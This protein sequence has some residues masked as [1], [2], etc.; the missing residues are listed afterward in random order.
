MNSRKVKEIVKFNIQ[1]NIQ[2]KWFIIFNIITLLIMICTANIQNIQNYL[3]SRDIHLF[4][5]NIC[6]EI[7]DE[8]NLATEKL[9]QAFEDE[10]FEIKK[11]TENT[12]SKDTIPDD[13]VIVEVYEEQDDFVTAKVISKDSMGSYIYDEISNVLTQVRSDLFAEKNEIEKQELEKLNEPVKIEEILLSVDAENSDTKEIIKTVSTLIIYFVS[14]LVFS[15]IANEIAQEKVSKS[16]EYVLTSV[17]E[18]EYLLAKIISVNGII[19]IQGVYLLIY[20]FIGNLVNNVINI[21]ALQAVDPTILTTGIDTGIILYIITVLGYGILTLILMSIIQATL[22]SKTVSMNEAGN[23]TALLTTI[24]I[25]AYIVTLMII[26]PYTKMNT[27]LY[28]LSCIPLLSNYFIPAIMVIGQATPLQIIISLALLIISIPITF[29]ICA[30]IFKNGV[31]DYKPVKNRKKQ[32]SKVQLSFEEEQKLDLTKKKYRKL[33]FVVGMAI[34][35]Y[36]T[37]STLLSFIIP[38]FIS[39]FLNNFLNEEQVSYLANSLL[40]IIS[41]GLAAAFVLAYST[42]STKPTKTSFRNA[43]KI[44]LEGIFLLMLFQI[45]LSY[46]Y[47]LIGIDYN[48]ANAVAVTDTS[49]VLTNILYFIFLAI[50]PAIFEELLF[51]KALITASRKFGTI[52]AVVFSA[53]LFG[54]IHM[55]LGQFIFAFLIGLVFGWI[56]VRTDNIKIPMILHLINNGFACLITIIEN[57]MTLIV[58]TSFILLFT[59]IGC[60]SLVARLIKSIKNKELKINLKFNKEEIKNYK[61]ILTD[62]TFIIALIFTALQFVLTEYMLRNVL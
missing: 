26:T 50:V 56:Y 48:I 20:Y 58:I 4:D 21:S 19:L 59:I 34:I 1:K 32:K 31:L 22:S 17:T 45:G 6:I 8:N 14:I 55:N 37:L 43:T 27:L 25:L 62:Y 33:G 49:N 35:M 24:T 51:R 29:N 30:V 53:L 9:I 16:I 23:T 40:S 38:I 54:F 2:N 15:K 5:E 3:E 61:Y 57:E 36:L 10:N 7:L 18:K 39:P 41:L 11:I 47:K 13:L 46:I 28:I 44:I 52:F 42:N 60:I 12:Y